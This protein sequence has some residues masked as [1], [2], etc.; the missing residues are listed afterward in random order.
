MEDKVQKLLLLIFTLPFVLLCIVDRQVHL[1]CVIGILAVWGHYFWRES[2]YGSPYEFGG[3]SSDFWKSALCMA[4]L[5]ACLAL[6]AFYGPPNFESTEFI[7]GSLARFLVD[8]GASDCVLVSNGLEDLYYASCPPG[9]IYLVRSGMTAMTMERKYE[10]ESR[11]T[12]QCEAAADDPQRFY[13]C[14]ET[15]R[16]VTITVKSKN[17]YDIV[18]A[19]EQH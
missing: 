3:F 12:W 1:V 8:F 11:E 18:V 15:G 19:V 16:Q 6:G 2:R 13:L 9:K 10:T 4:L 5:A 7:Q 17:G 14:S